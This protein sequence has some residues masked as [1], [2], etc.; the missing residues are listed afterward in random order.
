MEAVILY[1][2]YARGDFRADSDLDI[3]I[4]LD[5]DELG[6]KKY[7]S[8]LAADTFDFNMEKDVEINPIMVSERTFLKWRKVYPFYQNIDREGVKLYAA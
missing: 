2:S 1:G 6:M 7:M 5:E 4:I 8:R 3:C